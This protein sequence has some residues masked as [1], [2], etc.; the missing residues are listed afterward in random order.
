MTTNRGL[1]FIPLGE[2]FFWGVGINLVKKKTKKM[3]TIS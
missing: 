3:K 1:F 2:Y